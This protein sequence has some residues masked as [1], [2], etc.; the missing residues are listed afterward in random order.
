MGVPT[1]PPLVAPQGVLPGLGALGQTV[2]NATLHG[3]LVPS[4]WPAVRDPLEE[5]FHDA[6]RD[7]LVV[8][9]E[10][11]RPV[12]SEVLDQRERVLL[13]A[14]GPEEYG[15]SIMHIREILKPPVLTEVPR[16]PHH[17][18]G[19]FSLRGTVLPVVTLT[20][21]LGV[22]AGPA[23]DAPECRVLV[24]GKGE[25]AVGLHV[26]RVDQVVKMSLRTLEPPPRGGS[27]DRRAMLRGLGRHDDR[28]IIMVELPA[29][30]ATLGLAP[31][32]P[33]GEVA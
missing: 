7:G 30:L 9:T 32:T 29:L 15:V 11:S 26:H 17:V 23:Y 25:D 10:L 13:F 27:S 19:V 8:D 33:A 31:Q 4:A 28:L 14:V 12:Q 5:F 6:Q 20:G 18:L 3:T 1:L 22:P 24:V 21:A 2:P 16:A